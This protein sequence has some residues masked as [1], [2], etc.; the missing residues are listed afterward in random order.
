MNRVS[1]PD[2]CSLVWL[3]NDLRLDDNTALAA[4]AQEGPVVACYLLCPNQWQQHSMAPIR[5]DFILRRLRALCDELHALN[6]PMLVRTANSYEDAP[7]AIGQLIDEL[8]IKQLHFNREYLVD[9]VRRDLQVEQQLHQRGVRCRSYH[10]ALVVPPGEL[11]TGSG[12]FYK[13]YSPFRKAWENLVRDSLPDLLPAP[14]KQQLLGLEREPPPTQLTGWN[15]K[16][17]SDWAAEE[18]AAHQRLAEFLQERIEHY[19]EDRD[20]PAAPGTSRLSAW[21]NIGALSARRALMEAVA[22]NSGELGTGSGGAVCWMRELVWREF[23]YHLVDACPRIVM[24]HAFQPHTEAVHWRSSEND[25]EAWKTGMTGQPLVDAGMR[26][27]AATGWMHNRV[28]MITA[29]FLSKNL[30]LD[31]RLGEQ[32]FMQQLIDGD[33]ALNNGGWQWSASTGT[34][35]APYFRVFNPFSQSQ[36]FDAEGTYI[37]RWVPELADMA[38][39]DLHDSERLSA[40]RPAHYPQLIVDIKASRKRAISAFSELNKS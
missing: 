10:D 1:L 2:N 14:S 24:G 33:F 22:T 35:A 15:L 27:L 29:M 28:R 3:R 36:R 19:K 39:R 7:A 18:S 40:T 38:A 21:F 23:Y 9:E 11:K 8:G 26:Q 5:V 25:L 37:K 20:I 16:D 4:A 6:I 31:W 13:V 32:H 30:L 17:S 34:D 12:S